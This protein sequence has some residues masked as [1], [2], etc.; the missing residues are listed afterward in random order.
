MVWCPC[1][2]REHGPWVLPVRG[3][4]RSG[5]TRSLT[6]RVGRRR[7]LSGSRRQKPEGAGAAAD[8]V[9]LRGHRAPRSGPLASAGRS[10]CRPR[11]AMRRKAEETRARGKPLVSLCLALSLSAGHRGRCATRRRLARPTTHR[12]I[13][14][15]ALGYS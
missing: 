1:H 15:S 4:Q 8:T 14:W 11:A 5:P 12:F 13:K 10:S 6:R 3:C 2:C 7:L 9:L